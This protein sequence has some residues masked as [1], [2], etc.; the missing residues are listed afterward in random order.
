[1]QFATRRQAKDEVIDW[2]QFTIT[3]G[4][5]RRWDLS[6]RWP[7]RKTNRSAKGGANAVKF[8]LRFF[9]NLKRLRAHGPEHKE[10]VRGPDDEGAVGQVSS[11]YGGHRS[12][13]TLKGKFAR[14]FIRMDSRALCHFVYRPSAVGTRC[15]WRNEEKSKAHVKSITCWKPA[16]PCAITP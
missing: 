4:F 2:L 7:S 3:G 12:V 11:K 5:T 16:A 10:L 6:A 9:C 14:G 8:K 1:M 13:T 15:F